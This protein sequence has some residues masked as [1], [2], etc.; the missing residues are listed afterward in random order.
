[1]LVALGLSF[2]VWRDEDVPLALEILA[3]FGAILCG[4][5]L[6]LPRKVTARWRTAIFAVGLTAIMSSIFYD[7]VMKSEPVDWFRAVC[8]SIIIITAIFAQKPKEPVT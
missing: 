2:L 1:M 5:E 4:I 6:L 7:A 3:A 8:A